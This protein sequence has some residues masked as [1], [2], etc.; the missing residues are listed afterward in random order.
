MGTAASQR[1]PAAER[2]RPPRLSPV[3]ELFGIVG[4]RAYHSRSP[5]IH[6]AAYCALD[7]PALFVPLPI[8]SFDDFW[9][10]VVDAEE[11]RSLGLSLNG[12][13]VA[14]LTRKKR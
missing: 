2:L 12:L 3:K 5:Y 13:T 11:L 6:N 14:S 10:R 1:L 8:A 9:S 7:F 4:A